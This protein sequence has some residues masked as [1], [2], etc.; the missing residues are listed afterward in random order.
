MSVINP[1]DDINDKLDQI[2]K[3]LIAWFSRQEDQAKNQQPRT[4][5]EDFL[6]LPEVAVILK[7]PIGTI[8]RYVH[9]RGLPAKRLG[10]PYLVKRQDLKT[11]LEKWQAE[12]NPPATPPKDGYSKM[13]EHRKRYAK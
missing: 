5:S 12:E 7:K 3:S 4:Y 1:F 10:K 13:L 11:W 2:Q 6:T 9:Y 8:R